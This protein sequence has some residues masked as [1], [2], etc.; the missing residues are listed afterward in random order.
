MSDFYFDEI[1][2]AKR[3]LLVEDSISTLQPEN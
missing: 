1:E 3:A 2:K